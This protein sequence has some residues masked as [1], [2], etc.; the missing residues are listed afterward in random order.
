MLCHHHDVCL[1]PRSTH[2]C[3]RCFPSLPAG[4]CAAQTEVEA[5]RG[6]AVTRSAALWTHLSERASAQQSLVLT[7]PE[8]RTGWRLHCALKR[9]TP[10]HGRGGGNSLTLVLVLFLIQPHRMQKESF[11]ALLRRA[12]GTE[13]NQS[14]CPLH[15]AAISPQKKGTSA[16]V[17]R[18]FSPVSISKSSRE[19]VKMSH[20]VLFHL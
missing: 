5:R 18:F 15:R 19:A 20:L 1:N 12:E 11:S 16:K 13:R 4:P 9:L 3:V 14:V 17:S 10:G 6:S 8:R 7:A 2:C